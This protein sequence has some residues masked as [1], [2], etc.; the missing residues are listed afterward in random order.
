MFF[1]NWTFL[2]FNND[3]DNDILNTYTH[4]HT[5]KSNFVFCCL[6]SNYLNWASCQSLYH[7]CIISPKKNQRN[8]LHYS[9]ILIRK[10]SNSEFLCISVSVFVY[11]T[12]MTKYSLFKSLHCL[13]ACLPAYAAIII[14]VV[15]ICLLLLRGLII[16]CCCC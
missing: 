11:L 8:F 1:L 13:L 9:C 16:F 7:Y 5:P 14:W 4:T 15:I 12:L 6:N 3:D 2:L 10:N